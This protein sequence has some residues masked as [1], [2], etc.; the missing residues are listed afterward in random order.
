[1]VLSPDPDNEVMIKKIDTT[2]KARGVDDMY[3]AIKNNNK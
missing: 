2:L 3:D 1:M